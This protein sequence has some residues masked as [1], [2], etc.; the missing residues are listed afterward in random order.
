M[1]QDD[2]DGE[3][4]DL[5][6]PDKRIKAKKM[7]EEKEAMLLKGSPMCT[8]YR[9]LRT[10]SFAR[11]APADVEDV[12]RYGRKRNEFCMELCKMQIDSGL[13]FLYDH[14][15]SARVVGMRKARR[16]EGACRR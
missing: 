12:K 6:N 1:T 5:N 9:Q 10:R 8:A 2:E 3:P 11:M 7:I 13:Y 16:Y 15:D 4:W 14:P